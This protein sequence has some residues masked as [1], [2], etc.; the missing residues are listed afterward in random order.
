MD[1]RPLLEAM[2]ESYGYLRAYVEKRIELMRL[3]LIEKVAL[4]A[5]TLL[6]LAAMGFIFFFILGLLT[7]ALGFFLEP[8]V[9]S[10]AVSFLIL[11]GIYALVGVLIFLLRKPLIIQPVLDM[12][13]RILDEDQQL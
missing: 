13:I 7:I 3:E 2:G 4:T 9:G 6:L 10:L 5:S 1:E 11:A 8:F 12:V